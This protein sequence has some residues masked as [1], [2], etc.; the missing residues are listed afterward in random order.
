MIIKDPPEGQTE[1]WDF[2]LAV[3]S[4]A[5]PSL[6][7]PAEIIWELPDH[8][9][10]LF[11]QAAYLKHIL[12]A[13]IGLLTSS[14]SALWRPL[15]GSKPTGG[16]MTLKEAATLLGFRPRKSQ[17]EGSNGAPARLVD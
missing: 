13:G 15:S 1:P 6:L 5:E 10:G 11:P 17:E 16:S 2:T 9:S 7:I 4:E 3:R 8:Q 14:S 12:L